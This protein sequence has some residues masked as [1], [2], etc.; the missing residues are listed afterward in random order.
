MLVALIPVTVDLVINAVASKYVA[1]VKPILPAYSSF[2][3]ATVVAY[4]AASGQARILTLTPFMI[5]LFIVATLIH[6]FLGY[7]LGYAYSKAFKLGLPDRITIS[8]ETAMQNPG[9]AT[10]LAIKH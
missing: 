5:F 7:A 2:A 6:L 8:T 4:V 9:L 1:E 10:V 3:V